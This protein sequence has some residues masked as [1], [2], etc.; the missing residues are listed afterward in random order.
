MSKQPQPD[1]KTDPFKP[2]P[3][4]E[5]YLAFKAGAIRGALGLR[6]ALSDAADALTLVEHARFAV[7]IYPDDELPDGFGLLVLK[8]DE[9]AD[10][11]MRAA[12]PT[13]PWTAIPFASYPVA[14]LV[15]RMISGA[16]Q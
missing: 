15:R 14:E 4:E 5:R 3:E 10:E 12:V 11:V 6:S 13:V 1:H 2:T 9:I 16:Q 8:G 7:G